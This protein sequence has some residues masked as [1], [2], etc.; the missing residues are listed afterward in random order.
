ME[1]QRLEIKGDFDEVKLTNTYLTDPYEA[2]NHLS[3]MAKGKGM[4]GKGSGMFRHSMSIPIE[5]MAFLEATGDQDWLEYDRTG[6]G[7]ALRRL[8][9]RFPYWQVCDGKVI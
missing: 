2:A 5:D 6:S 7:S 1:E 4:A 3:R 8:L 9:I